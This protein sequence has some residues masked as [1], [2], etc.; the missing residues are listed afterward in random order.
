MSDSTPQDSGRLLTT[1][2]NTLLN[3]LDSA[4]SRKFR[5]VVMAFLTPVVIGLVLSAFRGGE[6]RNVTIIA[7]GS[8]TNFSTS[9]NFVGDALKA[10]NISVDDNDLVMPPSM[11]SLQDGE[12]ITIKRVTKETIDREEQI[13]FQTVILENSRLRV[14]S[15]VELR[16]GAP[17]LK[18][19]RLFRETVSDVVT[20]EEILSSEIAVTPISRKI[21]RGTRT[22]G[23]TVSSVNMVA[24][25]YTAGAESCW[26]SV[27]GLTAVLKRA[28]YG[29]AAV[30][31]SR[32]HLG[33]RLY[34]E[35]Y[36]FAVACDVGGAIRG[37]RIDLFMTNVETARRFGRRPVTV[38]LL[39]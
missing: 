1:G 17:G 20:R 15:E 7:D 26:P 5:P 32:I 2:K 14:G 24:T 19:E 23:R 9:E 33:T 6:V 34:V 25:A 38:H 29:V 18:R 8:A 39:D 37:D 10:A 13:P 28:G 16:A 21:Y 3:A 36:G 35:G 22:T 11:A 27:D 4:R 12:V 31:P 30:D